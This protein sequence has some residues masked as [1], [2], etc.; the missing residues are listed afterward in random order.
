MP[1]G[2][3]LGLVQ[4]VYGA[5]GLHNT[6]WEAWEATQEKYS[7]REM[8]DVSVPVWFDHYGTYDGVYGRFGHVVAW[9]PGRGFLSSPGSGT[10]QK[11]L[12][13]I[14]EIERFYN[15]TFVGYSADINT[16]K[17]ASYTEAPPIPK[18]DKRGN[19]MLMC[20]IPNGASDGKSPKFAIFGAG[21]FFEFEGQDEANAWILQIG[22]NQSAVVNRQTMDEIKKASLA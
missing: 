6:A 21:F 22:A 19:K 2:Y 16:V 17:V 18:K 10:G 20:H 11:W 14:P 12:Q 13:T 3:C 4:R 9:V 15:C 1:A 7:S 5:P 8:P